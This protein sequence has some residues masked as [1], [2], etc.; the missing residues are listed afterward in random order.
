M[1]LT[2]HIN[3]QGASAVG[4][5]SSGS[6]YDAALGRLIDSAAVELG[7]R[8]E[9]GVYAGLLGPSYETAA[10]I[11]TLSTLG[12]RAVGMS[13]V[14]EASTAKSEGLRVAA[15]SCITNPAAGIGTSPLRHAE[16]VKAGAE[17]AAD[18]SLLLGR[19]ISDM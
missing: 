7:I 12:A 6:P 10:E 19:V 5:R 4:A 11:R 3:M 17:V 15:I 1:R 18:F 13:T 9:R 8:L 14:L 16:V 2:D